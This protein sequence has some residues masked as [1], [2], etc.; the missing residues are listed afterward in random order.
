MPVR[1][2]RAVARLTTLALLAAALVAVPAAAPAEAAS[3]SGTLTFTGHGWGHGRGMG[4][5]GAL[6]YAVDHGWSASQILG[7]Y[8]GGTT[9]AR[10]A[11]NPTVSI[12]I[13]RQTGQVTR[14][15]GTSLTINGAAT[16]ARFL[17]LERLANGQ[18]QSYTAPT[19]CAASTTWTKDRVYPSGV[20]IGARG[21]DADRAN[22]VRLCGDGTD[23]AYRGTLQAVVNGGVQYTVNLVPVESYLR[24]VVPHEMPAS[25]AS[26][27]SGRGM[28]A[29]MAQSV[30]ARSYVLAPRSPRASG[31]VGCDSTAC[32]VY[33]GAAQ[34]S[35]T[36]AVTSLEQA[37]SDQAI[38]G[39]AG[40]VMRSAGGAIAM[41]EFSSS[42]GGWTAG[43]TFPA[44]EDL[45][46]DYAGN[47][48]HAW[49]VTLS[50][51]DV[52]TGLGTGAIASVAV[53]AR[54]GLGADGGRATTVAVTQS[55]GQVVTF[56]GAQVRSRLGLKSD[57]FSVSGYTRATAQA[58]VRALYADLL[59]R[60]VDATG[61]N[62]WT[63]RLMQ[64]T[65]QSELVA[66]LTRSDEYISKRVRQAYVE[67]LGREPEAAGAANW[68]AVI[69]RGGQ[70][71]DDVQ[72]R[73]YDSQEYYTKSGGTAQGYVQRLFRTVLGRS[74]SASD[75]AV[76]VPR[77]SSPQ[78]GRAKVVDGIWFSTEAAK[79]RAGA[80]YR[81]FLQREPDGPG[82]A[83]WATVL[84]QQGEGAVRT[85]IA[86]SMEYQKKAVGRFPA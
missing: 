43:G 5:Y 27:G 62:T 70:T 13:T 59:G 66:T 41:T 19:S 35:G 73:F 46:D 64:G 48:N 17:K 26:L 2:A 12:E 20:T 56:T 38:T 47:P 29:L 83:N 36:G 10:D 24:G 14:V 49:T 37:L 42:T 79:R 16:S 75:L 34:I 55:N 57:W 44:V 31:A 77:M 53:T 81:V 82:L 69:R 15:A 51:S 71:V 39:T 72:R 4:Q 30:A 11:G 33:S 18:L 86:G 85:G 63:N 54:N 74:A 80:Y 45:G 21:S 6:G 1:T 84:L 9:L 50:A 25:W 23:V 65:S 61:L 28:Q 67:V 40:G 52:A 58:V 22:L 76:W 3:D 8:Y 78:W 32:Q 60:G 7:H 68:L